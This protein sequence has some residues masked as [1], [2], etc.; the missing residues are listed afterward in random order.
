MEEKYHSY[1][2]VWVIDVQA[3]NAR[4]AALLAHRT[5][6]D[7]ESTANVFEVNDIQIDLGEEVTDALPD[8][9]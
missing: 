4:E 2:V 9:E 8:D 1:R 6:H 5:Q 3:R 7:P